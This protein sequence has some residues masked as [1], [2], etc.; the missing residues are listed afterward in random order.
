VHVGDLTDSVTKTDIEKAFKKFGELQEVWLA[1]NPPCFAFAV[2]KNKDDAQAAVKEM[3]QRT[4][5]NSRVRVTI[6][7]PRT[8]GQRKRFDPNMRCYQCGQ[9]GHF[10]RECDYNR[11][12]HRR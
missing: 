1:K 4:I 3:D 9:R 10:S 12:R 8:R 5:G 2:F 11:R 6:A 7:R